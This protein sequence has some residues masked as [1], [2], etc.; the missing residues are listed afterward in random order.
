MTLHFSQ[1]CSELLLTD[2]VS[3]HSRWCLESSLSS[4]NVLGMECFAD[5]TESG[6]CDDVMPLPM[7]S[8]WG[9]AVS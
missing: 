9:R 5:T 2:Q 7:G 1:A 3:Q 6:L 4:E 8:D